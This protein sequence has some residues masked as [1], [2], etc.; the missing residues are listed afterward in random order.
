MGTA[1]EARKTIE[2]CCAVIDR[3][4]IE[5]ESILAKQEK[6][7]GKLDELN[8]TLG[9]KLVNLMFDPDGSEQTQINLVRKEI[10]DIEKSFNDFPLILSALDVL[11]LEKKEAKKDPQRIVRAASE[12][13]RQRELNMSLQQQLLRMA[14]QSETFMHKDDFLKVAERFKRNARS[15]DQEEMADNFLNSLRG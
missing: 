4:K 6:S 14:A 1:T 9:S 2:E 15:L 13:K 7:K 10:S 8:K 12:D 3:V 5:R 11:E